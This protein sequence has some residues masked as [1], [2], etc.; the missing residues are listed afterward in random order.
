MRRL[1]E[2]VLKQLQEG[3]SA[4]VVSEY[5]GNNAFSK[6]IISDS[7]QIKEIER[8]ISEHNALI[9]YDNIVSEEFGGF[10]VVEYCRPKPRLIILGGGHIAVS[11]AQMASLLDFDVWVF[12]DRPY[13]ANEDRFPKPVT[14]VCDS[15]ENIS[16]VLNITSNDYAAVMTRGHKHDLLCLQSILKGNVPSYLGMIGSKRRSAI[17]KEQL[18]EEGAAPEILESIYAPIGLSI[19]AVTPAEIAV[20]VLAE[21]I[22]HKRKGHLRVDC[23]AD[24]DLIKQLAELKENEKAAVVTVVSTKGSVP[25]EAGA[26]MLVFYDGRTCG[27]IGG[28]C[29]EAQVAGWCR[30]V[31]QNGGY[32]LKK[33]DMAD[34][35]E[36]DGMVCGGM[37][38]VLIENLCQ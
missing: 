9:F 13:F 3:N 5:G 10:S 34:S 1:Y 4:A 11:F 21:I 18:K 24:L 38:E 20:S 36:E 2:Q 15:F 16:T 14:V 32:A 33:V 28:G 23:Y 26:K 12:D 6:K 37:M 25:R 31:I 35:A 7:G 22:A 17:V 29:A 30:E 8:L 19:G 27:S